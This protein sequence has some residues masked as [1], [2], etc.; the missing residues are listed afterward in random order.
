MSKWI[1]MNCYKLHTHNWVVEV[2]VK[3]DSKCYC[4]DCSSL[5][6]LKL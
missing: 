3:E 1:C 6:W 4:L 2:K 5:V